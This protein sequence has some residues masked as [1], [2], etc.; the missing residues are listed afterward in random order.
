MSA[1]LVQPA[2]VAQ[3]DA[4]AQLFDQYRQFYQQPADLA[5]AR[6]F[7]AARMAAG[8][9]HALL[10][11]VDG[12]AL[13]FT[14]LYPIHS[15]V[16]MRRAFVLN[17]LY[18]APAARRRGLARALIEAAVEH[19]RAEGAVWLRLETAL[20]NHAAQALY[21]QLGWQREQHFLSYHY[22]IKESQ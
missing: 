6:R 18:V 21:E 8:D 17:D 1:I 19:A 12:V 7:L 16:S 5:A 3:L 20:D 15:S 9:A 2:G 13:G 22:S 4:L 14:Q 10:G 11:F